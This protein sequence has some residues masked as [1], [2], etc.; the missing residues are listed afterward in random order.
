VVLEGGV[1]KENGDT[2]K[3]SIFNG[4]IFRDDDPVFRGIQVPMDF[5]KIVLWLTDAGKLK[6]TAFKLTQ[7]ELVGDI[8]FEEIDIDQNMKFKPYQCSI[9]S[10]QKEIRIDLSEIAPFDTF[11]KGA[12]GDVELKSELEVLAHIAKHRK[13]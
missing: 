12:T 1:K 8:D 10:L 13:G 2:A 7:T 5:Y 11:D 3:V 6:A 9:K 4:P